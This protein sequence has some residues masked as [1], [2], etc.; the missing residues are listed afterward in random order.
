MSRKRGNKARKCA[1]VTRVRVCLGYERKYIL[2]TA[3]IVLF[4][5][6][7]GAREFNVLPRIRRWRIASR[8]IPDISPD[9]IINVV[10]ATYRCERN[11]NALGDIAHKE[12]CS[13]E[14]WEAC[15]SAA[16]GDPYPKRTSYFV[17]GRILVRT[18]EQYVLRKQFDVRFVAEQR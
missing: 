5:P 6:W 15:I 9:G 11:K 7:H 8:T 13:R 17:R 12:I 16:D 2:I 3:I 14:K 10:T 4:I 1:R 18:G